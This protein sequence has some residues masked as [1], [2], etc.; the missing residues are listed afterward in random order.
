M[1]AVRAGL[2]PLETT[3]ADGR[4]SM[5]ESSAEG[6]AELV[7]EQAF[8]PE[9]RAWRRVKAGLLVE[10]GLADRKA[11]A[12]WQEAVL[13]GRFDADRA[14]EELLAAPRAEA[15]ESQLE[16]RAAELARD[17]VMAPRMRGLSGAAR[18][19][20]EAGRRGIAWIVVQILVVLVFAGL[21]AASLLTARYVGHDLHA[22][23]DRVL[24]WVGLTPGDGAAR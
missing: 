9:P 3:D 16:R 20:R 8:A 23:L 21:F 2:S 11:A 22:P 14:A 4:M 18:K 13:A 15:T 19:A 17:L 10:A 5:R 7:L 24:S 6:E 12:R 1:L